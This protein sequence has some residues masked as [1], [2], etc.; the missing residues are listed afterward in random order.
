LA[1]V[2][3]AERTTGPARRLSRDVDL[4]RANMVAVVAVGFLPKS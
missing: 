1:L 2:E 3:E 4:E